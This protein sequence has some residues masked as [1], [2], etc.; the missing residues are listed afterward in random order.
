ML[1][2]MATV[3]RKS[4]GFTPIEPNAK[5][6]LEGA[7]EKYDAML[8]ISG[9]ANRTIAFRKVPGGYKGKTS[10]S[11]STLNTKQNQSMANLSIRLSSSFKVMT[12]DWPVK[13]I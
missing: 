9:A 7:S 4:K 1:K 8:H 13:L 11:S 5:F 10:K 3:D 12:N 2:A 6:L